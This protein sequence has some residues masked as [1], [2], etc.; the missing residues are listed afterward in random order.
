LC[1]CKF[2]L[3]IPCVYGRVRSLQ[4]SPRPLAEFGGGRGEERNGREENREEK[5]GGERSDLSS[6]NPMAAAP[7]KVRF[8]AIKEVRGQDS[9]VSVS[10]S[11][12]F[13]LCRG[14][15]LLVSVQLPQ[16]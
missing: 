6:K 4:R 8:G 11:F 5:R 1:S 10:L 14:W 13:F 9:D 15:M 16:R 3:K 12:R 7:Y 2:S